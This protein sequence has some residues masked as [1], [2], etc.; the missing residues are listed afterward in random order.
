VSSEKKEEEEKRKR[1]EEERE[2]DNNK[3]ESS[4][5]K[6]NK[7][8][9]KTGKRV[10]I[11]MIL[12]TASG[13]IQLS[14]QQLDGGIGSSVLGITSIQNADAPDASLADPNWG[15]LPSQQGMSTDMWGRTISMRRQQQ[16]QPV[17]RD[18]YGRQILTDGYG[19]PMYDPQGLPI[20][21]TTTANG[22]D[23]LSDPPPS[24]T[25]PDDPIDTPLDGG[26]TIL[27]AIAT[28]LGY[29]NRKV[30]TKK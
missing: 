14:A 25:I 29:K 21:D 23:P 8:F 24:I 15:V 12:I 9:I 20:A 27:L 22:N 30:K 3:Q 4:T 7:M 13:M 2:G 16:G 1:N 5:T 19:N 18:I 10:L 17:Y 11:A 26:V 28:G 6:E